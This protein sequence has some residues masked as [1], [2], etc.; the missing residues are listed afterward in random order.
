M[1]AAETDLRNCVDL[2]LEDG[3]G[4]RV[5]RIGAGAAF[6]SGQPHLPREDLTREL[7][8]RVEV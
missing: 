6:R 8:E 7:M 1:T 3:V 2:V 4:S 5:E